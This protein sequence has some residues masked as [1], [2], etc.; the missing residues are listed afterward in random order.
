MHIRHTRQDI[1]A[2][3]R[4]GLV[5][6]PSFF[7]AQEVAAVA[8]DFERIFPQVERHPT[9]LRQARDDG[10][11]RF[12]ARQ[13][14]H[15][16][17]IP[18]ACS[19]ALNLAAVHPALIAMARDALG[20]RD[21]RL[22]QAQAWAKFTG[23]ADYDQPFHVDYNNH[24]LTVPAEDDVRNSITFFIYFSEVTDAHG[25][26]HY[27]SRPDAA[28]VGCGPDAYMLSEADVQA[29]LQTVG[30][31][32]IAPAGSVFAYGI[33]VWHR[34]SNLTAPYAHRYVMTACFKRAG[35]DSIGYCAWPYH[36]LKP[37]DIIF[38]HATPEQLACFGVPLPGDPFWT[39]L[40]LARAQ[41]RRPGW[42]MTPWREALC[43][44]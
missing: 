1:A 16:E 26:V 17:N 38:D 22:Y 24:T 36:H 41:H 2:W 15:F 23:E 33:D 6:L 9:A 19:P 21:V 40:T 43:K 32:C 8:A 27:V 3:H 35:N 44:A 12:H 29:R 39:T 4:E 42:D 14:A 34:G 25:P 31:A 28:R 10:Q 20:M 11:A 5:V 18:F 30:Q 13:F 37:W 7:H